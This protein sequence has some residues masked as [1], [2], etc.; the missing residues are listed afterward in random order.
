MCSHRDGLIGRNVRLTAASGMGTRNKLMTAALKQAPVSR[1]LGRNLRTERPV[2]RELLK[3][4]KCQVDLVRIDSLSLAMLRTG[5][6]V[7]S[8]PLR[9]ITERNRPF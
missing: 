3:N 6:S 2:E 8:Y 5:D 4:D 1:H 9:Q 7:C